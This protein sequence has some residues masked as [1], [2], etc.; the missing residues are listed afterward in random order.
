[1]PDATAPWRVARNETLPSVKENLEMHC[2][3]YF[4][5]CIQVLLLFLSKLLLAQCTAQGYCTVWPKEKKPKSLFASDRLMHEI[6]F[7]FLSPR[8]KEVSVKASR[9]W[10]TRAAVQLSWLLCLENP[11]FTQT[12]PRLRTEFPCF[13]SPVSRSSR[14][15]AKPNASLSLLHSHSQQP[16]IDPLSRCSYFTPPALPFK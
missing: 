15:H 2:G 9:L 10:G 11:T 8:M 4:S 7:L 1:M 5:D 3:V 16:Q 12:P 6:L 14:S 13:P